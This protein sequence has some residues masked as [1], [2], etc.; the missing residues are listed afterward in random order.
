MKST[1]EASVGRP[2]WAASGRVVAPDVP[3][4]TRRYRNID[5][6]FDALDQFNEVCGFLLTAI[7]CLVTDHNAD[8]VAVV[9]GKIDG[10]RDL[11]LIT[12]GIFVDPGAQHNLEAELGG[13]WRH[14][15]DTARRR[16]QADR[17]GHR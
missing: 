6:S 17:L 11:A 14:K 4:F 15:L 10:R 1:D 13:N 5:L 3:D 9:L 8:N 16:I 7:N 12:V 2:S